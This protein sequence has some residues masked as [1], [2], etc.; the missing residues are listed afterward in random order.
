MSKTI[1][2]R[3]VEM[4]FNNKDFES[5]VRTSLST[6]DNLKQ[7]LNFSGA[8]KGLESISAAAKNVDMNS[9]TAGVERSRLSFTA[10][11]VAA[12][13][14]LANITNS[15]VNT[16]KRLASSFTID[17]I[18]QGFREYELKMGSVQT[19]L[20]NTA[21]KGTTLKD[22]TAALDDLNTYADKT[23]YNFSE[24]TRNIGTFT[25]AGVDLD[26]SVTSIKGISNLAAVSGSSAMQ[27]STAM[28]QLSQALAAGRVT[29]MDW[30]SVVN[31]GMGGEVFQNALKR[32]ATHF[33][34]NVDGMIKKYGS[35]RESLT[36]GE[37]LTTDI[38]TETLTQ[39]SGAY[40]EADLISQGYTKQQAKEITELAKTATAAA[41]E[42]KTFSSLMDTTKEALGSGWA[43]TWELIIGDFD[44]A[45]GLF[46][47]I[48]NA[49]NGMIDASAT[50]RNE[51]LKGWSDL[52]GRDLLIDSL[53]NIVKG[54]SSVLTP[55]KDAFREIFPPAT[56][57]NLRGITEAFKNFT[58]NLKLSD[59][60]SANL[61][62]TFKG[63]FSVVKLVGKA[64]GVVL[65]A[66]SPALKVAAQLGKVVLSITG[67][68]G[69]FITAIA[70]SEGVAKG[71]SSLGNIVSSVL[72]GI[73]EAISFTGQ[74]FKGFGNAL[75]ALGDAIGTT[76]GGI[77]NA[78]SKVF[79]WIKENISF[80][81][82]FAGLAGGGI[83]VL[84]KK[85]GGLVDKIKDLFDFDKVKDKVTPFKEMLDGV[86]GALESFQQGIQVASLL[87]IAGAVALLSSALRTISEID[88]E[89]IAYS[90]ITIRLL[91]SSLT[92]GF[93]TLA[94]S[95][96]IFS[97]GGTIKA[98]ITMLAM[99][100]AVGMLAEALAALA[101]LSLGEIAKGLV[102]I[103][104]LLLELSLAIRLM[105]NGGATLRTSI[106]LLA[107]A[108]ACQMLGDAF[109]Q[110]ANLS[111]EQIGH[112]LVAMGGALAEF[113]V[114]LK[115]LGKAG[116]F[117]A[118]A[119]AAALLIAVK[120]LDEISENL[121][122]LGNLSWSQIGHG[123]V[124]MGVA[125]AE[126][127][128]VLA[129]LG[130]VGGFGAILG[131]TALLIAVQSLD[132]ISENLERLGNL[133]WGQIARGLAAMGGALAELAVVSGVLGTVTNV[134]GL[135]GAVTLV[136]GVQALGPLA[137]ALMKFGSMSWGDIARGLVSMGGALAEL[138]VVSGV[139]GTLTGMSGLI[140]ATTI[141]VG[142][143]A[144]DPLA[145]ALKKF[146]SMAWDEIGRGLAAMG[147]ALT[148]LATVSG[149]L[150]SLTHVFG[151]LGAGTLTL[152]VQGLDQLANALKKFGE[153]SWDEIGRGLAAMGA[154][155]GETALGG[156]L[157]TLSGIGAAAIATIAEPLG[158]LADSVKKWE[159]V[160]VPEGLGKQLGSLASGIAAFNLGGWGADALATFAAPLGT[161]A[162]SVTKWSN[163]SIPETLGKQIG[164]L[165]AGIK[166]FTFSGWGA[167]ALTTA[168]PSIGAMADSVQKWSGVT[169]PDGLNEGLSGLAD[170][171]NAFSFA[172]LGG[173]SIGAVTGPLGD[174]AEAVKKWSGLA[175]PEGISD[176]LASLADGIGKFSF[177]FAAGWSIGAVT[178]P[179][180]DLAD[181]VRKWSGMSIIGIGDEL[182][183]LATG[184]QNLVKVPLSPSFGQNFT[185]LFD[186]FSGESIYT[187]VANI[188]SVVTALNSMSTIDVASISTFST[189]LESLGR[190]SVDGLV[191]SL[192]NGAVQVGAAVTSIVTTMQA[193]LSSA[194]S[195]VSSIA[196]ST[197]Q[198]M[199]RSLASGIQLGLSSLSNTVATSVSGIAATIN[200]KVGAFRSAGTTLGT[201]LTSGIRTGISSFGAAVA[202]VVA[203]AA[204]SAAS[205]AGS[206]R[207]AGSSMANGLSTGFRS[208]VSAFTSAVT[209]VLTTA[210]NTINGR[211][212]SFNNSGT[213]IATAFSTG[214]RTRT[215]AVAETFRGMLS[216]AESAIRSKYGAFQS[217]GA[218]IVEGLVR[219]IQSK[220][221]SAISEARSLAAALEQ[222]ATARLDI[223]SPSKVFYKIGNFVVDG[224]INGV[225]SETDLAKKASSD[226]GL[227]IVDSIQ[228]TLEIHSPS[229]VM[230]DEVGRYI[231]QGIAEGIT[232]DMSAEDAIAKKA[233]NIVSAFRTELDKWDLDDAT[234]GLE[235]KLWEKLGGKKAS[236]SEKY[237]VKMDLLENRLKIQAN[238]VELAKAEHQITL[239]NLGAD[240][241]QTQEAYNKYLQEQIALVEIAEEISTSQVDIA[242]MN[243]DAYMRYY[244]WLAENQETM[245]SL[246][247]SLEESQKAAREAVGYDPDASLRDMD[248][249]VQKIID[250]VMGTVHT[251]Y[252][253]QAQTA[254]GAVVDSFSQ[255][256]TSY[257]AAVG[258][259][260]Q[261]GSAQ[262]VTSTQTVLD[263]T[264]AKINEQQ[265]KWIEAGKHLVDGFVQG[266]R[267]SVEKAASE[268]ANMAMRAYSAAMDAIN[269]NVITSINA[270]DSPVSG[271]SKAIRKVSNAVNGGLDVRPVIRPVLDLSDVKTKKA[272]LGALF[273]R[274]YVSSIS[275]SMNKKA[276]ERTSQ[277]GSTSGSSTTY[278]FE[279]NNYSPKALSRV[280]I[281]RQTRNQFSALKGVVTG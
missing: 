93:K 47:G 247:Y 26:K 115:V 229:K 75:S 100:K 73:S 20:A 83:F 96:S 268:A 81:D 102:G 226:V 272:E 24:M 145:N 10:L 9:V 105:G 168:A 170:G 155:M 90:L 196:Q 241:E 172:A 18:I 66:I 27:A 265:P 108:K 149:V 222:A 70:Q 6:L 162:D 192:Q 278:K 85:L 238:K 23:I 235:N 165:A 118:I 117:T 84:A 201:A 216:Q 153:M 88:P 139:L 36:R 38:L 280:E 138:A 199:G 191:S 161:L 62:S 107:L 150:G 213:Q 136:V 182:T 197:G 60:T 35:F 181:S 277:N 257:A 143:Q 242:Q 3:V 205:R 42:V 125:L 227:A 63:L 103:G 86:H 4:R 54:L 230:R 5:N 204:A 16:G 91:I 262:M 114:A 59:Q 246:G 157:N 80:G 208:G 56:A 48:S 7:K 218:Y 250:S 236:D 89:K 270:I 255:V 274:K 190:V 198:L 29:L 68:I 21:A 251:A 65:K 64:F 263:S 123:L 19:I 113:M 134:G 32:T 154:A 203:S 248:N 217:A 221:A 119:G 116:S 52:G 186:S 37:W 210:L 245:L 79:T 164:S 266:I 163:V 92:S 189:A 8:S 158:A 28:Y 133:S 87:A 99:A 146:G 148:E 253:A 30:N 267:D 264:A 254:C 127:T 17:P 234:V 195:S 183:G 206:F 279:Q 231:V 71:F 31:A 243:R 128:V 58:A 156:L 69:N 135:L 11:Q 224:L 175:I 249:D 178:G 25:A 97:A 147:G 101:K 120:S 126:L 219:G 44:Q 46:T 258:Q 53:N 34:T 55:I 159:N 166:A 275:S 12:V 202:S 51:V 273:G 67:A 77:A 142:V 13:T 232:K 260:I 187:A 94:K 45:K 194:G 72:N 39:L 176:N 152:G 140:G 40:T 141:L 185:A 200:G 82:V 184:L 269:S 22:V 237:K 124:A 132:E 1:D 129:V 122:R 207:S 177:M 223:N 188:S 144:L 240:S 225:R 61:K 57:E 214:V 271:I 233:Q 112:G 171:V 211:V 98:S 252:A 215:A 74:G 179:L 256:S 169:I 106:A 41:T 33:G 78:L 121:E 110:F 209:S 276:S 111:W 49:L 160:T 220:K 76:F 212:S 261:A 15:A 281:Y 2:E 95:L 174:L 50:A 173:W 167:D 109:A 130:K 239:D 43:Q 228:K 104:G 14:A 193:S 244:N 151:L 137:D 131:G 259:G 180:G